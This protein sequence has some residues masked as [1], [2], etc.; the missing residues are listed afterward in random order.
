MTHDQGAF[1]SYT[2]VNS[3][4]E[5]MKAQKL[6]CFRPMILIDFSVRMFDPTAKSGL[7]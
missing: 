7:N 1:F 3:E 6:G 4:L 2:H 5:I